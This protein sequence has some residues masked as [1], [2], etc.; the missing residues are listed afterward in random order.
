MA[1]VAE[2][3]LEAYNS[4]FAEMT[5]AIRLAGMRQIGISIV[6]EALV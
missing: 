6:L 1:A 5:I 4:W 3:M 2:K